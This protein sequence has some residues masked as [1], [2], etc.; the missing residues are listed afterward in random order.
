MGPYRLGL[1]LG[2]NSLGWFVTYLEK[3]GDRY[4]PAALGPGGV[5]I[6]PDGRDPQSGMSNA[7]DRRMARGTRKRRDRFVERRKELIAALIKYGLFP[8]NL[9]E[10]KALERIDP[11]ALRQAALTD[12]LPAHHVGRALFHLNQRRGFQSNRKTD[13]KQSED[14]AIK[15]AASK[16]QA[17]MTEDNA[18]TLGSFLADQHSSESYLHRQNAVRA[19]LALLGKDRLTGNARKKAWAKARKRL[20]GEE[21]LPPKDA[22][23]GVRA[24]ATITGTKA[25]YDFYPTRAMLHD[26]FNAIWKAQ[27]AHHAAMTDEA[28]KEIEHIIFFQRPLKPAIVGKCTLDP[29]TRPFKED[30]EGYRAPWSHPLAQRFRI[31]SEARNL[32]IRETGKGSRKLTKEQSDLVVAALLANKD[33]KFDKLRTLLKLPAEAKFNLESDRRTALDGD[34]T[35]ARLSDKKGFGKAW[36][37]FPPERLLLDGHAFVGVWLVKRTLPKTIESDVVELRKAISAREL[38]VFETTGV[39]HRP[40]MTFEQARRIGESKVDEDAAQ[41]FVCAIDIARSRSAG[42]MPLASHEARPADAA[43]PDEPSDV[44]LPAEPDI[45]MPAD[46][47]EQKPTTAAGRIVR[48]QTKLLDLSLRNRLLNFTDSKKAVSFVC[49]DVAFLEDRLAENATIKLIS[50]PEQNPLGERDAELHRQKNG[51]DIHREFAAQALL[52]DELSSPLEPKDLEARLIA[53]HRQAK[54]DITEGGTNTLYL[55]IG[56][57]KWKKKP[58]DQRAYRA[59]IILLPV[60]L[61]RSSAS[62]RFRLKFHEDEPRLNATLLQF[63]KRDFDLSLPDFRDGL[64]QDGAGVDVLQVIETFRHAVRDTPGFEV[65]DDIALSTFSF[66]KYLMWKDLT[67][68]TDSL[69][70]NRVVKHLIDNPERVFDGTSEP[71]PNE[72]DIDRNFAPADIVM[73]LPAD[74]SQIAASLAAAQGR[75]FVIV[76]PPGTGKSQTIANMIATCLAA[77]K[78]VLF[79]AEKTAALNVVYRRLRVHGLGDHCLELHSNKADRKQFFAQLKRSWDKRGNS[80]ASQWIRL[81][82]RLQVRRDQLNAYVEALHRP[83]L[84]G[85]TPYG[86]MGVTSAGLADHAPDLRWSGFDAHDAS[87]YADLEAIAEQLGFTF[88]AV[89]VRPVLNLVQVEEWSGAWQ[90]RLIAAARTLRRAA[91]DA[92]AA[93]AA[94]SAR[95]GLAGLDDVGLTGLQYFADLAHNLTATSGTDQTISDCPQ[96]PRTRLEPV[97]AM[98]S[99]LRRKRVLQSLRQRG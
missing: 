49:P 21:T 2:S 26:E 59:P 66:A 33:V 27:S 34:Q 90:E 32:E 65:T 62:A 9:Q 24:R 91:A 84:S 83:A 89:K 47:V 55:A 51:K 97:S 41:P 35:A 73:P 17:A 10:R 79:V 11:Y 31:L 30:P 68:R 74:S 18:A 80:G 81:N 96:A 82:E 12:A 98:S 50:L 40:V 69:R 4:E 44:P 43:D 56:V 63:A 75:D 78:T 46:L 7:V 39:T 67:D 23:D 60:K 28:R 57:L 3:R 76:G 70:Q 95:L 13:S 48:W 8:D 93:L 15:Q 86:A 29:A 94:L 53:L 58:E 36:R 87:A 99:L 14:G 25:S 88:A 61:E 38:V 1:D 85:L 45:V 71:F 5:R 19:E 52:R 16:L 92:K 20:F 54:S 22:P 6:F 37:G 72:R 42:I 77:K 64:P